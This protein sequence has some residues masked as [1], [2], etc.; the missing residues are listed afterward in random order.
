MI[1]IELVAAIDAVGTVATFCL[2]DSKFVTTPADTPPN[3][4]FL[5]AL[6]NPGSIG[7]HAYSDGKTTGGTTK[8]ETGEI[9]IANIDGQFDDWLN[10]SF[11]G[12][13]VTIRT[14]T[15]GAYPGAFQTLFVGTVE[16]IE[17]DWGQITIRL[18]DK[19]YL[20]SQPTLVTRYAGTNVLPAGFEG[21]PTDIMGKVKPRCYGAVFNVPAVQVNTAKLTYQINDGAVSAISAVYD[22]GLALTFSAD[23]ATKE[24]LQASAPAAGAF[25]TCLAEGFFQL[26][27][28]AAGLVTA[29]VVQGA[30]AADRTVGQVLRNIALAGALTAGEVADPDVAALDVVSSAVV[31]IWLDSDSTTNQSAM[32]QVASSIGAW[33]GFDG[34][35]VLRM[36]VLAE[37]VGTPVLDLGESEAWEAIERRPARD[38]GIPVWRVTMNYARIW[39]VQ[40]SDLAGAVLADRR[41]YLALASR[42]VVSTSI[43]VKTKYL[44][45]TDM[46]VDGLLAVAND[47][48]TEAARQLALQKVRRDIFDVP[49]SI[50]VFDGR[51]PSLMS[52]VRLTLPRF[53]L[54]AGKL[55]RLIGIRLELTTNQAILT[56]WG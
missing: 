28:I 19:Q 16:S 12:R 21:A 6:M 22:K 50:D 4:A 52:V 1:L 32:D 48:A 18:R 7:L 43:D 25:N 14:G 35:G 5:D 24:L 55:F 27:A 37:P 13:P 10:Y 2:S 53:G 47:A 9:V 54:D 20:F 49:V 39:S 11:D 46:T 44:L 31:G 3:V 40:T 30:S 8:L 15:G 36:G 23:F 33:F 56:L 38:S 26:G 17:A 34:N 45:A 41:A 42:S 29:D 51:T